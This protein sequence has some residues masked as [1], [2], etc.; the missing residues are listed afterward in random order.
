MRRIL[1]LQQWTH[2]P[3][4]KYPKIKTYQCDWIDNFKGFK[5]VAE[6]DFSIPQIIGYLTKLEL[7]LD[8]NVPCEYAKIVR[9]INSRRYY[10]HIGAKGVAMVVSARDFVTYTE[11]MNFDHNPTKQM[12]LTFSVDVPEAP[13]SSKKSI[14][15]VM[16]CGGWYL[17]KIN[18][19]KTR[20]HYVSMSDI[21]G[22]IPKWVLSMGVGQIT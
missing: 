10:A 1:N 9:K 2:V 11:L 12:I 6:L 18:P 5:C 22:S 7:M 3:D 21:K 8:Y 4:K 17:E 13:P 20:A 15:G 16:V 19:F 14:R